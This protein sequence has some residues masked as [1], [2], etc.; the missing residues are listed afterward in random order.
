ML[1]VSERPNEALKV[2]RILIRL[3]IVTKSETTRQLLGA[4]SVPLFCMAFVAGSVQAD[5][6]VLEYLASPSPT[7]S[8]LSRLVSD[9]RGGIYLSWV[10]QVDDTAALI[11]AQLTEESWTTPQTISSG[12]D[13]FVNWADFPALS[14]NE[15]N[16][17]AHW[18]QMSALGTYDYDIK[19]KFYSSEDSVWSEEKTIHNDGV[20]AEHGFVSMLALS[21]QRTFISWLDG[22]QTKNETGN[23]AMTLRA[24][25]FDKRG[26]AL[27]QWQLDDRVCD[28]C[29]TSSALT[30]KGPI[31]VYRDRSPGE[32][33]DIYSTRYVDGQWSEPEPVYSDGWEIAG[34]PVNGPAVAATEEAVAIAWFSAKADTPEVKLALSANSGESFT[35]PILVAS[36]ETNGRVDTTILDSGHVAVSWIDTKDTQAQIM[37]NLY[38]TDG[39]LISSTKIANTSVSRR[40]GFPIIESLG[41][42]VYVTWTDI[43]SDPAVKVARIRFD[44]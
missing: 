8:S 26:E 21:S 30:S 43:T 42:T 34:C 27:S 17:T 4:L 41:E 19:A 13:W 15:G 44:N 18:L 33:R 36:P 28:C 24:A 14:V 20:A 1:L 32:I 10:S 23:N 2:V 22:R 40:S 3:R 7:N 37:L 38:G 35:A 29:Q 5:E 11:F 16:I 39:D 31:V 12:A 9:E 6:A 25:I